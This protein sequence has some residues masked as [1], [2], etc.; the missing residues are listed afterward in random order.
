MGEYLRYLKGTPGEVDA[1]IESLTINV[2]RFFRDPLTFEYIGERLLPL[3][4]LEQTKRAGSALRMWSAGCSMGEEPYSMAIL[5]REFS[6]KEDLP[7]DIVIFATDIDRKVLEKARRAC[8]PPESVADVKYHLLN[9]YFV[10]KGCNF[11]LARPIRDM[12][13]FSAYDLLDK[14]SYAPPESIFGGFDLVLCRNV[15]IY[16]NAKWQNLIFDKLYRSL[17]RGGYLVLGEAETPPLASCHRFI[18]SSD[19]CHIYRRL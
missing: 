15:L 17:T 10:K 13:L 1:L 4:L 18:R 6:E 14:R 7:R 9:K 5:I 16:F 8:Y 19:C 11:Q 12:V 3:L 2:S